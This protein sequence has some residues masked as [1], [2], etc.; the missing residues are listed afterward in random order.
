[1]I[2]VVETFDDIGNILTVSCEVSYD[3]TKPNYS[4]WASDGDYTGYLEIDTPTYTIC[5]YD[6]DDKE[7]VVDYNSLDR[8]TQ[9]RIYQEVFSSVHDYVTSTKDY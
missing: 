7:I 8:K 5:M 1:M 6:E 2:C 4:S 3:Y 9:D